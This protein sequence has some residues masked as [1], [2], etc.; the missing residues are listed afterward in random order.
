[1]VGRYTAVIMTMIVPIHVA[2]RRAIEERVI[3]QE[4][5]VYIGEFDEG[6]YEGQPGCGRSH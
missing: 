6:G 5:S 2:E 3:I 4:S 1:M